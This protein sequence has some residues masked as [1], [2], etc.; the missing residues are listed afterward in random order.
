MGGRGNAIGWLTGWD[1]AGQQHRRAQPHMGTMWLG[2]RAAVSDMSP[3]E[4][5]S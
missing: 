4:H 5:G 3:V 2:I 1:Q